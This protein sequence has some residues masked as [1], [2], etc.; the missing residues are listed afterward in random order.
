[1]H[2]SSLSPPPEPVRE[3]DLVLWGVRKVKARSRVLGGR[4][5]LAVGVRRGHHA[6]PHAR[7]PALVGRLVLGRLFGVALGS[8][9]RPRSCPEHPSPPDRLR[10][11]AESWDG[12]GV[13]RRRVLTLVL[14]L[15]LVL[16]WPHASGRVVGFL[17]KE[18][19]VVC[20]SLSRAGALPRGVHTTV[21]SSPIRA[22]SLEGRSDAGKQAT[23]GGGPGCVLGGS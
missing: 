7:L 22:R 4:G 19:G 2:A 6:N 1:M 21:P 18:T 5:R 23:G 9:P 11:L 8:R 10:S 17:R 14:A 13:L 16:S 3:T 20:A 15:R 12:E